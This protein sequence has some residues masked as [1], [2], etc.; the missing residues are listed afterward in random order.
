[1]EA[2]DRRIFGECVAYI[3]GYKEFWG[4]PFAVNPSVLVPRPDTETLIEAALTYIDILPRSAALLELCT[5]SGAI[6][7][8][9]KYEHPSLTVTAS[10]ISKDALAVARA[11]AARNH[12]DINFIESNLFDNIPGCFDIIVANPP[13]VPSAVIDTLQAEVRREPRIALDGGND[14]L[15][16]IKRI[17]EGAKKRLKFA[18]LMEASPEQ[19]PLIAGLLQANGYGDVRVFKDLAGQDR[20][21]GGGFELLD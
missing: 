8:A 12:T 11:N 14:G 15:A 21:I 9:L 7:V 20:V 4:L 1:M 17:V 2:L 6:A 5:G 10:D 3:T 16:I 19:I 18:L 13:Y